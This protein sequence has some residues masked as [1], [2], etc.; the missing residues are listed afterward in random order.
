MKK[1][2]ITA[3]LVLA[4]LFMVGCGTSDADKKLIQEQG[5]KIT[6]LEKA[7]GDLEKTVGDMS[8]KL[9]EVDGFLKAQ[10][11]G[12]YGEKAP[13]PATKPPE[14]PKGK[15]PVKGKEPGKTK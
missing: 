10:N 12:K 1:V 5:A 15:E 13:E 8:K 7:K 6:A 3:G 14:P 2:V 9:G 11:P 4:V